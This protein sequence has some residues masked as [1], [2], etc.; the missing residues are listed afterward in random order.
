MATN[1]FIPSAAMPAADVVDWPQYE[2]KFA[3]QLAFMGEMGFSDTRANIL[4]LLAA[5]GNVDA[6]VDHMIATG[7]GP[8]SEPPPTL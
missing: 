3:E 2:A 8:G 1:G 7:R 4:A 6:A 5:G